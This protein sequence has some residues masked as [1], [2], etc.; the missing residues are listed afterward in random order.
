ML[1][2]LILCFAG[3]VAGTALLVRYG[4]G[5]TRRY[6]AQVPQRFHLGQVPRLGGLAMWAASTVGWCWIALSRHLDFANPIGGD[7]AIVGPLW[8]VASMTVAAGILEDLTQRLSARYR[9]IATLFAAVLAVWLLDLG[10]S[11][12]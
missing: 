6:A 2:L 7:P 5:H 3:G 4:R 10:K 11:V 12:V 8:V 1:F 9:L